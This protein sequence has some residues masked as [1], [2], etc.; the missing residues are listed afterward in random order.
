MYFVAVHSMDPGPSYHACLLRFCT[1]PPPP[2]PAAACLLLY[3]SRLQSQRKRFSCYNYRNA[4]SPTP[5]KEYNMLMYNHVGHYVGSFD[6]TLI[7]HTVTRVF[8]TW[9]SYVICTITIPSYTHTHTAT[10]R[11][12]QIV[13]RLGSLKLYY[14]NVNLPI[15]QPAN[16]CT[17]Q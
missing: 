12:E 9:C 1:P 4:S 5:I 15:V 8:C 13:L 3:H 2:P 16:L 11:N 17:P 14:N 7:T 6:S 10:E